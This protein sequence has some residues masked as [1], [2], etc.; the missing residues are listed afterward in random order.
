VLV[1]GHMEVLC[2]A[3]WTYVVTGCLGEWT[4]GVTVCVVEWTY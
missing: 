3:E 1:N 4:Y 2:V